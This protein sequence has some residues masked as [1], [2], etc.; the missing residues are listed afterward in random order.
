MEMKIPGGGA[1]SRQELVDSVSTR[2]GE[3]PR[4]TCERLVFGVVWWGSLISS[5]AG[6]Q[7]QITTLPLLT[8]W[9]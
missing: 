8:V 9:L 3:A 5:L 1:K 7:G 4:D 6:F 2:V